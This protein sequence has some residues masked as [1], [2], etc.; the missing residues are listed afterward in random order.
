MKFER[1]SLH[2]F[3]IPSNKYHTEGIF[4]KQL[5]KNVQNLVPALA[6]H[7]GRVIKPDIKEGLVRVP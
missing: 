7:H 3:V 1:A 5:S 4:V 2:T 6:S